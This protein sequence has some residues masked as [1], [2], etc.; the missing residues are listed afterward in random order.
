MLVYDAK[1][2]DVMSAELISDPEMRQRLED[3]DNWRD[4]AI[5]PVIKQIGV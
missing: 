4:P 1:K 3:L 5:E 2:D